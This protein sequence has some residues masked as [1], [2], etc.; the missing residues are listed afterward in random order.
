[1]VD[2]VA[3]PASREGAL[4]QEAP[5]S[6]AHE[7]QPEQE[8]P[9]QLAWTVSV[10]HAFTGEVLAVVATGPTHTLDEFCEA[11]CS[12]LGSNTTWRLLHDQ[13]LLRGTRSLEAAGLSGGASV[14]AIAEDPQRQVERQIQWEE[15]RMVVER[16]VLG[17]LNR[18]SQMN[19]NVIVD[20]LAEITLTS[21]DELEFVIHIIFTKVLDEPFYCTTYADMIVKLRTCYPEFAPE[22][23]DEKPTT[24]TRVLLGT[25]QKEFQSL[26]RSFELPA[27]SIK[28]P[29]AASEREK[30]R[31]DRKFLMH[32]FMRFLGNLFLR[33]LLATKVVG[34]VLYDL[35]GDPTSDVIPAEHKI[36]GACELLGVTGRRLE[37]TSQGKLFVHQF[38]ACLMA[39]KV[40]VTSDGK[41]AFPKRTQFLIQN[42]LDLK[43]NNWIKP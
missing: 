42:L 20:R 36:E 14:V 31:G 3:Q 18:I 16:S 27:E 12:K 6:S 39:W 10:R 41:E 37:A 30:R 5:G 13:R 19:L 21:S 29:C 17:L 40:K 8:T 15:R 2:V 23:I 43:A 28:I 4:S 34:T 9:A 24:F 35:I 1:M 32:S 7:V 26:L 22:W 25:C 38:C 11:A 33:D